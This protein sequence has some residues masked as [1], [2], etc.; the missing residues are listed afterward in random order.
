MLFD[1]EIKKWDNDSLQKE[2]QSNSFIL[3]LNRKKVRAAETK[4]AQPL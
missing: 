4:V 1:R 3:T 2:Q